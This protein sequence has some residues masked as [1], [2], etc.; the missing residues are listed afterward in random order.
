[1]IGTQPIVSLGLD[2]QPERG[3]RLDATSL[4]DHADAPGHPTP[5]AESP[6][7]VAPHEGPSQGR[8][9][10]NETQRLAQWLVAHRSEQI[11][12][13]IVHEA[14]RALLNF[15]AAALGGCRHEAVDIAVKTVLPLSGPPTAS[16]VGRTEKLDAARLEAEVP[17][18]IEMAV[19]GQSTE[20]LAGLQRIVPSFRPPQHEGNCGSLSR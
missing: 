15:I 10:V 18:L 5:A 8:R 11:P 12:E 16:L 14:K 19:L 6:E 1:M 20:V 3:A 2:P 17:S 7:V 9:A 4:P 13:R